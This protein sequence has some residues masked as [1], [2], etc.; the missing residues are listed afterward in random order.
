MLL[1]KQQAGITDK[2]TITYRITTDD[3]MLSSM[4]DQALDGGYKT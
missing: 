4:Y 1:Y 2:D 3:G